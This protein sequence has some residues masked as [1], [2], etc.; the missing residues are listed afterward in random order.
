MR[1]KYLNLLCSRLC[2]AHALAR[3][4]ALWLRSSPRFG[5][6]YGDSEPSSSRPA[7]SGSRCS[8]GRCPDL[9]LNGLFGHNACS[10]SIAGSGR[11][12]DEGGFR[13]RRES[14]ESH[15]SSGKLV[16]EIVDAVVVHLRCIPRS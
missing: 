3:N 10:S 9:L 13:P 16:Q 6:V 4:P 12:H 8:N 11:Y 1:M 5:V 15:V 7:W 14:A 2:L